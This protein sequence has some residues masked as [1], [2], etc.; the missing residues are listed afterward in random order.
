MLRR[1][2]TVFVLIPPVIYLIGWSPRWL[3][4]LALVA[5]VELGLREFFHISRQA[6]FKSFPALGYVAGAAV[7]VVPALQLE[8]F[9]DLTLALLVLLLMVISSVALRKSIEFKDYL[10]AIATTLFGIVYVGVFLSCLVPLRFSQPAMGERWFGVVARGDIVIGRNLLLL[11]F[12]VVW[13]GDMFAYLIG[14]PFGRTPFFTRISPRKTVEGAVAGL[15]GSLLVAWGFRQLFWKT[16]DLKT[17]MLLAGLMALAGQIG[18]LVES[19]MKRGANLK[20]SGALLPGHGGMLDRIDS[21]LFAAPA[22]WLALTLR[23]L[24]P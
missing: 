24:W 2:I 6:G 8:R 17:V 19:A 4:L 20:D 15:A 1:T 11:L 3:F 5:T 21:L 13:A 22:L 23:D 16:A 7:A 12:L 9:E 14:R 10:G 18:D